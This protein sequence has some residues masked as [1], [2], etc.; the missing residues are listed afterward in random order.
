MFD[1]LPFKTLLITG[2]ELHIDFD[3]DVTIEIYK[4]FEA[5]YE[6]APRFCELRLLLATGKGFP[7]PGEKLKGDGVDYTPNSKW[8]PPGTLSPASTAA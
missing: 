3:D 6:L 1:V 4:K 8:Y 7:G 2:L 5:K